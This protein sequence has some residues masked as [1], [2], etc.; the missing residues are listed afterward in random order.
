VDEILINQS[1]SDAEIL[2]LKPLL[3]ESLYNDLVTNVNSQKYIDLM[4]GKSYNYNSQTY[5]SNS[6]ESVLANFAYARYILFSSYVDTPF[7]LVTKNSQDS[8]GVSSQSKNMMS[9]SAEQTAYAY[10]A[11]IKDYLNRNTEM[12]PLWQSCTTQRAF[13]FT[14]IG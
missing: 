6:L 4:R 3:G 8:Q 12:Y 13:K 14:K 7:G 1:I 2:D 5:I 11:S 10:F 9:K